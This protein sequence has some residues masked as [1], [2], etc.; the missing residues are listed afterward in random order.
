MGDPWGCPWGGGA[1]NLPGLGCVPRDGHRKAW[2]REKQAR[3]CPL[4]VSLEVPDWW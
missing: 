1:G 3:Q 2:E 4:Q